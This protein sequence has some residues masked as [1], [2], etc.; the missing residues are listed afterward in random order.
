M[1]TLLLLLLWRARHSS[2]SAPRTSSAVYRRQDE[3]INSTRRET[4]AAAVNNVRDS[5]RTTDVKLTAAA[6]DNTDAETGG[7]TASELE[8]V[9]SRIDMQT[10]AGNSGTRP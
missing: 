2:P 5:T 7:K 10:H 9:G 6:T 3:K 8:S 4:A 1:Q